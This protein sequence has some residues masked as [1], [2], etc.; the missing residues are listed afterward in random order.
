MIRV[1]VV[2]IAGFSSSSVAAIDASSK[3]RHA[4][5]IAVAYV[6]SREPRDISTI[7]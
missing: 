5:I 7:A 1:W 6:I 4:A 3:A 2:T